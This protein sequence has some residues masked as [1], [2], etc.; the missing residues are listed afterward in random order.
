MLLPSSH[1]HTHTHH[2]T[3]CPK[4]SY[5]AITRGCAK[6]QG[7]ACITNTR[8]NDSYNNNERCSITVLADVI[9][10]AAEFVTESC[11]KRFLSR[12]IIT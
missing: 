12:R 9:L 10:T 6:L 11:K 2:C 7:G 8:T 5:M 1:T 4:Y 3:H